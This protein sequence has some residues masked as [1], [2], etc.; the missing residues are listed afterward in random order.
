MKNLLKKLSRFE[1]FDRRAEL[2][3]EAAERIKSVG[4]QPPAEASAVS[5]WDAATSTTPDPA[6]HDSVSAGDTPP[7]GR[8]LT[9]QERMAARQLQTQSH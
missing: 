2:E 9:V 4:S 8:R 1:R 5:A 6:A 7:A 3:Q